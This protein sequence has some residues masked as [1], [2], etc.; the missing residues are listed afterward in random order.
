MPKEVKELFRCAR[1]AHHK[2]VEALLSGGVHVE[3]KDHNGNTL[4]LVAAQNGN[5]RIL[6][7]ALRHG[8]NINM[9]NV[10]ISYI[11]IY[12]FFLLPLALSFHSP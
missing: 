7:I 4:L 2:Q 9:Q 10:S 11:Y 8:G 1:H 12:I 6:K 3:S 5:K